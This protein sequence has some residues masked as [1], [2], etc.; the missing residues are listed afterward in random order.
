MT[1]KKVKSKSIKKII[2]DFVKC[3]KVR[4]VKEKKNENIYDSLPINNL[5]LLSSYET[6]EV[7][8]MRIKLKTLSRIGLTYFKYY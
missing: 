3:V 6:Y 8:I 1:L 2:Y 7:I 5:S 4:H